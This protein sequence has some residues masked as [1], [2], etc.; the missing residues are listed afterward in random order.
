MNISMSKVWDAMYK[1]FTTLPAEIYTSLLIV[2]VLTVFAI[3]IGNKIKKADPLARPTTATL[4]GETMVGGI[5]NFVVNMMGP[6]FKKF[7]PYFLFVAMY[8]PLSFISGVFGFPSPI[9]YYAVPLLLALTTFL[10]VHGTSIKYT[11][12][13][14]FKRFISPTP[15]LLPINIMTFPSMVISLSFRMFGNALAGTIIMGLVYWATGGAAELLLSFIK[16]GPFN[17]VAPFITPALHAY[18]DFFGAFIQT[19]VFISLSC[20]FIAAEGPEEA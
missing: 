13:G 12:W 1:Y 18:F 10:M 20:L 8:L 14:Y 6:R 11:K 15:V 2:I 7:A 19:I 4:I 16:V 3:V 17:F 9:S 5:E